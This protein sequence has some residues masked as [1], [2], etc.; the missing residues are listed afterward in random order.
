MKTID[1]FYN[2]HIRAARKASRGLTGLERAKAIYRYFEDETIHPHAWYTYQQEML[3]RSSDHQFPIDLMKD[4][5][6]LTAEND[7]LDLD[8]QTNKAD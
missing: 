2:K 3:N 7:L 4:M 5:V 6:M 8:N 1:H